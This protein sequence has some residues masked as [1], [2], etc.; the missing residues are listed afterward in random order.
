LGTPL[1][2][3]SF[4]MDGIQPKT[5]PRRMEGKILWTHFDMIVSST[6]GATYQLHLILHPPER[7]RKNAKDEL[8]ER[9][10]FETSILY[11]R[12]II[13]GYKDWKNERHKQ[14]T[15]GDQD[16]IKSF[17]WSFICIQ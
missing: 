6:I 7:G 3:Q 9:K 15:K 14:K 16:R 11:T 5:N 4:P 1:E 8:E 13:Q 2:K 12:S 10:P 17:L